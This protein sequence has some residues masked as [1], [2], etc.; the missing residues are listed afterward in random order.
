MGQNTEEPQSAAHVTRATL[1]ES[2]YDRNVFVMIRYADT[3]ALERIET[4]VRTALADAGL[5]AHLAKDRSHVPTHKWENIRFCMEHCRYGVAIY[6]QLGNLPLNPNI[7]L[8]LGYMLGRGKQCL[9]LRDANA[10]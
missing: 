4:E 9:I 7:S 1:Q 10:S 3:P 6:E 5:Q 2:D 8:E